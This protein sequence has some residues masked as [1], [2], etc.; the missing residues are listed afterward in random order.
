[1]RSGSSLMR[2]SRS[3]PSMRG[4]LRSVTTI[5]GRPL[6]DLVEAFHA[7]CGAVGAI[8]PG[9]DQFGQPGARVLLIFY[10]QNF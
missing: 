2:V 6:H 1:M 10:D 3:M 5:A 9:L 8:S 4:I 7:V